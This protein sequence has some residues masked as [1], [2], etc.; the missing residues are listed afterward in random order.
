ME[1]CGFHVGCWLPWK[2]VCDAFFPLSNLRVSGFVYVLACFPGCQDFSGHSYQVF[3]KVWAGNSEF[4]QM[5]HQW[6]KKSSFLRV[7]ARDQSGGA[8]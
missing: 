4:S 3:T 1:A 2:A 6:K 7:P 5:R 8:A